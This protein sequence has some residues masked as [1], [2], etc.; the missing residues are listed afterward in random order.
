MVMMK[1]LNPI[2]NQFEPL[3]ASMK[4]GKIASASAWSKRRFELSALYLVLCHPRH[5]HPIGSCSYQSLS[6]TIRGF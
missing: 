4:E 5:D 3:T 2:H 1:I 6:L